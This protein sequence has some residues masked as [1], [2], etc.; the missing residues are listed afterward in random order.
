MSHV[1]VRQSAQK[2]RVFCVDFFFK[3]R[4]QRLLD[5]ITIGFAPDSR[6]EWLSFP[7]WSSS[8]LSRVALIIPIRIPLLARIFRSGARSR[9]LSVAGT[10]VIPM[11]GGLAKVMAASF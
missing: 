4:A 8:R 1:V 9:T 3:M 2:A 5:P 10:V 7:M 11:I 6:S